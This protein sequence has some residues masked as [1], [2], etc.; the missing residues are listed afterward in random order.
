[1]NFM[2]KLRRLFRKKKPPM[3][4]FMPYTFNTPNMMMSI[5]DGIT[6]YRRRY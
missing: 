3:K 4:P 5:K 1:M 2:N 6:T